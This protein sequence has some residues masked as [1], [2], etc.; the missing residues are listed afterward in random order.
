MRGPDSYE[1]SDKNA[2]SEWEMQKMTG[3]DKMAGEDVLKNREA[4][5]KM[6]GSIHELIAKA[7]ELTEKEKKEFAKQ[8]EQLTQNRDPQ[9]IQAFESKVKNDIRDAQIVT[10]S[11][12][13]QLEGNE[14][15]FDIQTSPA[16]PSILEMRK[17]EFL[18]TSLHGEKGADGKHEKLR[19]LEKEIAELK[20]MHDEMVKIVGQSPLHLK[21][22]VSKQGV[23]RV[24]YFDQLK[25]N[26][27]QFEAAVKDGI[28]SELYD[29][30]SAKSMREKFRD[31]TPEEQTKILKEMEKDT[32]PE[33]KKESL[34]AQKN[35]FKKFSKTRQKEFDAKFKACKNS[36]DRGEVLEK[37]KESLRKEVRGLYDQTKFYSLKEKEAGRKGVDKKDMDIGLYEGFVE[38]F[39]EYEKKPKAYVEN[40]EKIVEKGEKL[41][42]QKDLTYTGLGKAFEDGIR[43]F[44]ND[45][46]LTFE[47][48]NVQEK[49]EKIKEIEKH[50]EMMEK[51]MKKT[52]EY[53]K[54]GLICSNSAH[55]Y[56]IKFAKLDIKEKEKI[57]SG[58]NVLDDPRRESTLKDFKELLTKKEQEMPENEQF[59]EMR[60]RDRIAFIDELKQK[61]FETEKYQG[62]LEEMSGM[63][64]KRGADGEITLEKKDTKEGSIPLLAG[65][66]VK[67][68]IEWFETQSLSDMRKYNGRSDLDNPERPF[69]IEQFEKLDKKIRGQH[70]KQFAE[71]DLTQRKELLKTLL[72]DQGAGLEKE[73]SNLKEANEKVTAMSDKVG[74]I[75]LIKIAQRFEENGNTAAEK[76]IRETILERDPHDTDNKERLE[77]LKLLEGDAN[78]IDAMK[79]A[80]EDGTTREAMQRLAVFEMHEDFIQESEMREQLAQGGTLEQR[81]IREMGS[82]DMQR[83]QGDVMRYSKE[84]GKQQV[85]NKK[86]GKA[87]EA[88]VLNLR[89]QKSMTQEQFK[90]MQHEAREKTRRKISTDQDLRAESRLYAITDEKGNQLKGDELKRR[91]DLERTETAEKIAQNYARKT[92]R[93]PSPEERKALMEAIKE[94]LSGFN[95]MAENDDWE[96]Q[97]TQSEAA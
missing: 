49:G 45:K 5:G 52:Q 83:L 72:P 29:E 4:V 84:H 8:L 37:M 3:K 63:K 76:S 66:S 39:K 62:K 87:E 55:E 92:G 54:K 50:Y 57:T 12:F 34:G 33:G 9:A 86:T 79:A 18:A 36:K 11:F 31:S 78:V 28:K 38:N 60:L 97:N 17:K 42:D 59:F 81:N 14:K 56:A 6:S 20:T 89:E 47:E 96:G 22:V 58:S 21:Q 35:E 77:K 68:Y 94:Q 51:W 85:M 41:E 70:Q 46:R 32:S 43:G 44:G 2:S 26:V 24:A 40:Y 53:R 74:L 25:K 23:E 73:L 95:L 69:L 90:V 16:A 61:K 67:S 71:G 93:E 15:L 19:K 65:K 30:E 10:R 75:E 7:A 80:N 1:S 64:I 27:S 91:G 82:S 13:S 88:K 48:L